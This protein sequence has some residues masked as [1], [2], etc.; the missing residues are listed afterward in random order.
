MQGPGVT[1]RQTQ[2]ISNI[3]IICLQEKK[4]CEKKKEIYLKG[5]EQISLY[6][7]FQLLSK[8]NIVMIQTF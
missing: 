1:R 5:W 7:T 2:L 3:R 6:L 4:L 8:D